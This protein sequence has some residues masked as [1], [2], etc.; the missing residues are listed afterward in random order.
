VLRIGKDI[1]NGTRL[2]DGAQIHDGNVIGHVL[3][4]GEIV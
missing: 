4:D 1:R 2:D 3:H